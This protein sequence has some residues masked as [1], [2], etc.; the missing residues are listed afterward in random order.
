[1]M[2]DGKGMA[3]LDEGCTFFNTNSCKNYIIIDN[4]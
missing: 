3:L 1:M 4:R 2:Y